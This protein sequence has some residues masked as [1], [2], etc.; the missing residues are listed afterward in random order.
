MS[1]AIGPR[2]QGWSVYSKEMLAIMEAIRLWRPYLMGRHFQIWTDHKSLRFFLEQ[3]VVT[4]KQQRWVSKLLG[5]DYEIMYRIGRTNSAAGGLSR[6][7]SSKVATVASFDHTSSMAV[8]G[9]LFHLWAELREANMHDPYLQDLRGKLVEH[10]T[11]HPYLKNHN[12]ILLY[13]QRLI[14]PPTSAMRTTL[15]HEAHNSKMG[16]HSGVF[17]THRRLVQSFFWEGMKDD[18]RRHVVACDDSHRNK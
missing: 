2:K 15:L 7:H 9:P 4:P 18:V 17:R 6:R 8:S 11:Q 10:P 14:I 3:R 1:K 16:G 12:G 13:K 5:Y